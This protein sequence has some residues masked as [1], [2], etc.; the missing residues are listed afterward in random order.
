M[1][2]PRLL[3]TIGEDH[4]KRTAVPGWTLSGVSR[5]HRDFLGGVTSLRAVGVI[6]VLVLGLAGCGGGDRK[7]YVKANATLFE[8]LPRFP[9]SG[10]QDE[11]TT[12]YHA[13]ESAPVDGYSTR[14][15]LTLP[16]SATAD[17]VA[18]FYRRRLAPR[19]RLVENLGGSVL[20]FR[21]GKAFLSVNLENA[22][23]HMLEIAV[24]HEYYGKLGR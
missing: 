8:Q 1:P 10:V 3:L 14:F 24:D 11:T 20:N 18:L 7:A 19:W 21:S 9:G 15:D 4:D 22:D 5:R 23:A 17:A 16:P 13:E 12:A 6:A 2:K